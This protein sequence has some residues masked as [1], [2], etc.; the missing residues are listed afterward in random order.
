MTELQ[1]VQH[2]CCRLSVHGHELNAGMLLK[3]ERQIIRNDGFG[4]DGSIEA[5]RALRRLAHIPQ[6]YAVLEHL[7]A[8]TGIR[9]T[10][11]EFK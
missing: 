7:F 11:L 8:T 9:K 1:A 3:K 2:P 5:P 6:G 10:R 4:L